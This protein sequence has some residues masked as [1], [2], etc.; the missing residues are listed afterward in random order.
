MVK[1]V[2]QEQ[3]KERYLCTA[4]SKVDWI[5]YKNIL[6]IIHIMISL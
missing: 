3:Q 4:Y 2:K 6:L 1:Y 5:M